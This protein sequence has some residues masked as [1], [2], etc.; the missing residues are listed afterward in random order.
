MFVLFAEVE[1]I[2]AQQEKSVQNKRDGAVLLLVVVWDS[3]QA[4][5]ELLG[6]KWHLVQSNGLSKTRSAFERNLLEPL[7]E[8]S[9]RTGWCGQCLNG[10]HDQ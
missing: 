6:T 5:K 1:P 9:E 3:I 10:G 7:L 8:T 2:A 4:G